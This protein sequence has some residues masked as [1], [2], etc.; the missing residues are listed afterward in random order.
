MRKIL[1]T[2]ML[3]AILA[4]QT[5]LGALTQKQIQFVDEFGNPV[6]MSTSVSLFIYNVG[7]TTQQTCYT[8]RTGSSTYLVTQA[9]TDDSANTPLDYT[10]GLMTFWSTTAGYKLYVSDGVSERFI[11]NLDGSVTRIYWPSTIGDIARGLTF[12]ENTDRTGEGTYLFA[13]GLPIG[14]ATPGDSQG[15]KME[16]D[17]GV[18]PTVSGSGKTITGLI[19]KNVM[20]YDWTFS[21]A[22]RNAV[23][24]GAMLHGESEGTVGGRVQGVYINAKAS[25]GTEAILGTFATGATSIGLMAI[26]ARTEL[27]N[28]CVLTTPRV[29]GMLVFHNQKAG[30]SLTGEYAAIQ[31]DEPLYGTQTG[32]KYGIYFTDDHQTAA[33]TYFDYAF[34]FDTNLDADAVAHYNAGFST[35]G[36][37]TIDGWISVDIDGHQLYLYLWN[38]KPS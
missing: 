14:M 30:S 12:T 33:N 17:Y 15:M 29:A 11:D 31:I 2:L 37:G 19:I 3:V 20:D 9:I 6:N 23:V 27:G 4:C 35:T 38:T 36:S 25:G 5:A 34:G 22:N 7:T 26:E 28:N 1:L 32:D 16:F 18:E 8:N 24:R 13:N 10:T 21:S